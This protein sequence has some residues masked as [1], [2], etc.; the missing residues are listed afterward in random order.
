MADVVF[1]DEVEIVFIFTDEAKDWY[2][3]NK[4]EKV[5]EHKAIDREKNDEHIWIKMN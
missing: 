4:G 1:D 2:L 5:P 3:L